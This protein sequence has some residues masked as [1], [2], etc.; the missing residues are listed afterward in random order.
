MR[1]SPPGLSLG[2]G[3]KTLHRKNPA[4]YELLHRASRVCRTLLNKVTHGNKTLVS[5]LASLEG[6]CYM[7]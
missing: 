1:G 6:L 4:C 7:D 2:K 3:L 5:I